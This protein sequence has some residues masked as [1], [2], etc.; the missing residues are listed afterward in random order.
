MA[1]GLSKKQNEL[2]NSM[3]HETLVNIIQE[4]IKDNKEAKLTLVNGY[5]LSDE[6][7]LKGI[8]KEYG[9]QFKSKRFYDYYEA[10]AFYDH[11]TRSIAQPLERVAGTLPEQVERLSVKIILEFE[12]FSENSDTSSGSWMDYYSVVLDAWMKAVVAQKNGDPVFLAQKIFDFVSNENYFG[13]AIYKTYRAVLGADVLRTIRDMYYE[14]KC[15]REALDI[16][17]LVRD[18]H[19][20]SEALKK[21]Q[22]CRSE[23]YFDYAKLLIEEVRPGEAIELLFYMEREG[24]KQYSDKT[25][26]D[27]LLITAL[28][29]DGQRDEAME[30]SIV[31]FSLRCDTRF[32]R[33]YKT[34]SG[35]EDDNIQT[36]LNIAKEK[37]LMPY[38]SFASDVARFDLVDSCVTGTPKEELASSL[39]YL[40]S[41]FIR[42][43]SS[44]LYQHGYAL[45][46][47]LLRRLLVESTIHQAKSK[48]YSYAASD[49]KKAIHYSEGLED[50]PQLTGTVA[51][52]RALYEQHK[53]KTALWSAMVEKIQGLSVG[54]DGIFYERNHP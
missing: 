20:L 11:L 35:K 36:F 51:Y 41:S 26:W 10:D 52:F 40:S 14:K 45:A 42:T 23:H 15:H 28:I 18:T 1:T 34:A 8:E 38:I 47:T 37:G 44:T 31:A 21:G 33:L 19:F 24:E 29:E 7:I 6:D 46:A 43:L 2:L 39:A 4:L 22:F 30:K 53:R 25:T 32:Y 13:C 5:L 17:L 9:R 27:K 12:R 50:S 3:S 49:M 16:S 54:K 48:Y